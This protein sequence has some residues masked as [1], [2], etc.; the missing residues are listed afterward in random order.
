MGTVYLQ[1]HS[2]LKA[3][4]TIEKRRQEYR[5]Q[6]R[7]IEVSNGNSLLPTQRSGSG[8]LRGATRPGTLQRMGGGGTVGKE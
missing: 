6:G 4:Q 2:G 7:I 5:I 1:M 3:A 8:A